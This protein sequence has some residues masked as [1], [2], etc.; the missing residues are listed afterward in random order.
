MKR[1]T[2]CFEME[3]E[4]MK[5]ALDETLNSLLNQR[6][7]TVH[8]AAIDYFD[9]KP[10][11]D[12]GKIHEVEH[13]VEFVIETKDVYRISWD[14]YENDYGVNIAKKE[15][16]IFWNEAVIWDVADRDEWQKLLNQEI[17]EIKTYWY[18]WNDKKTLQDV[19]FEFVNGRK[20][21]FSASRYDSE[22]DQ[23]L[24]GSDDISII[25]DEPT[26]YKYR[27]GNYTDQQNLKIETYRK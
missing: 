14:D 19:E 6:I 27:R 22:E 3:F 12:H 26:A 25:F 20:V 2:N 13:G 5:K 23:L 1:W 24:G 8:Y 9:D 10:Y 16:I 18:E 17:I 4:I 7:L 15:S 21:W 11:W